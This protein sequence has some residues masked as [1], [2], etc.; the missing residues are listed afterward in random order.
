MKVRLTILSLA[1]IASLVAACAGIPNDGRYQTH[2]RGW[3]NNSM[4]R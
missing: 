1:V 4:A 3:S 2:D